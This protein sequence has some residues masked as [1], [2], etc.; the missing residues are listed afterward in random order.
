MELLYIAMG[1]IVAVTAGTLVGAALLKIAQ[2]ED[3][4]EWVRML[5][6]PG[7]P[8][9]LAGTAMGSELVIG[10]VFVFSPYWG[11]VLACMWMVGVTVVLVRAKRIDAGCGCFGKLGGVRW[12]H[13]VRNALM[14]FL[15]V[16]AALVPAMWI[17]TDMAF[18]FVVLGAL[19]VVA[20][21]ALR[22]EAGVSGS[23]VPVAG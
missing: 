18:G 5:R 20:K 16:T 10:S 1:V 17:P 15:F 23:G 7:P 13:F 2:I 12:F 11:S 22:H 4:I 19:G 6:L 14:L 8:A 9:L 3:T 21:P